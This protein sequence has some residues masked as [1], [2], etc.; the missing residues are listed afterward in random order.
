MSEPTQ[1][2]LQRIERLHQLYRYK[3]RRLQQLVHQHRRTLVSAKENLKRLRK[4]MKGPC[5]GNRHTVH[6]AG[7]VR[8]LGHR[9]RA[10]A[11]QTQQLRQLRDRTAAALME[12]RRR[13]TGTSQICR[14][15]Q[16]MKQEAQTDVQRRRR[17]ATL[18]A[19]SERAHLRRN[20]EEESHA[21]KPPRA[22][23]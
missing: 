11:E 14:L 7:Q 4:Q 12:D 6:P 2:R 23:P 16:T 8:V 13:M 1:R 19:I 9:R 10:L 15:L 3:Y 17:L 20:A 18:E 22:T 21:R 5:H